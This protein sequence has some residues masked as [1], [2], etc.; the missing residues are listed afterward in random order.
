MLGEHARLS[1]MIGSDRVEGT[2]VYG[3]DGEKIGSVERILIEKRS[4]RARDIEISVGSF[5][6][7]GGELHSLPWEKFHYNP[8]LEGYQLGVTEDEL[9]GAPTYP[10]NARDTL[11]DRDYRT[12]TYDYWKVTPYW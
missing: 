2:N 11:Y 9:K 8:E 4:G 7:M 10:E 12:R 1:D 5:L 3:A 6:G